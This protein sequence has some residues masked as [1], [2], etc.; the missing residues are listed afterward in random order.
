MLVPWKPDT[1]PGFLI[2]EPIPLDI[3]VLMAGRYLMYDKLGIH[4]KKEGEQGL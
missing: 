2:S 1:P 4:D 3:G